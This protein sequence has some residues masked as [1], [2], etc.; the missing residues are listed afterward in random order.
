[1]PGER[2]PIFGDALRKLSD[3]GRYIQQDGDRYWIDTSP[4]L[5]RTAEDIK[6]SYLRKHDDL[7]FELNNLLQKEGKK[8]GGFSGVHAGQINNNEIPDTTNTRLVLLAAQYTHRRGIENSKALTWVKECL[9]SKGNVPRVYLNTLLFLAPDER[10]L[11]NLL[12]ALAEKKAW[13]SIKNDKLRLNLTA[14]Q[15]IQADTK[16]KQSENT[17]N[18]RIP[19]TWVHLLAPY[20]N[21]PGLHETIIEEKQ[22][23]GGSVS[24]IEGA[25]TK[26]IQEEFIYSKL[27]ARVVKDKLDN[28]LWQDKNHITVRDLIEWSQKYLFLPRISSFDVIINALQNTFAA[29]SGEKTF[30]LADSYDEISL[31]YKGLIPQFK[32]L[33][34]PTLN[35][36]I[37]K[38]EIAEAQKEEVLDSSNSSGN[39]LNN[40]NNKP[41]ISDGSEGGDVSTPTNKPNL[42]PKNF[43]GSIKLDPT[44]AGLKTSK[45]MSEVMSHLQ[46][47]PESEIEMTLDIHVKNKNG[48]DKQTARIVLENSITLKVDNPEIF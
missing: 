15:E 33:Y 16:I 26:S 5:N 45:F 29:E 36:L 39:N 41:V 40:N 35:S 1:M 4:N 43:T 31:R 46:A 20:Q 32:T 27:G 3:K 21:K 25:F 28:F 44:D 2:I 22:L 12:N 18:I 10:N 23:N 6:N 37:V 8:R 48:I 47:L 30:Y 11:E 19:E 14:S 34:P 38:S 13:Q 24:F 9:K 17:V 7:L 42:I